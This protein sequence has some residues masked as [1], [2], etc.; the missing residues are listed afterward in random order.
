[1]CI[2]HAVQVDCSGSADGCLTA[3]M[4]E[5]MELCIARACVMSPNNKQGCV[6]VQ[7]S[8]KTLA[9]GLPILQL[10]LN[11]QAAEQGEEAAVSTEAGGME[12]VE[13]DA[14][15][16]SPQEG[17][18]GSNNRGGLLRALILAPTRELAMQV[19]LLHSTTTVLSYQ[20]PLICGSSTE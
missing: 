13:G 19:R 10:L 16:E 1:M 5:C 17:A 20:E 18:K 3:P 14:D 8:G 15:E 4:Q 9:F 11:S 6:T 2:P 7:G 12:G